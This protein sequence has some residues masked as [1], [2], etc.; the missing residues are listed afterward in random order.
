MGR[1]LLWGVLI[2]SVAA[3]FAGVA[4]HD[5]VVSRRELA[6]LSHIDE[7]AGAEQLVLSELRSNVAQR[8]PTSVHCEIDDT[9]LL[10]VLEAAMS[11]GSAA[12]AVD[13]SVANPAEPTPQ[14]VDDQGSVAARDRGLDIVESAIRGGRLTEREADELRSLSERLNAEDRTTLITTL[15]TAMNTQ[16]VR[17]DGPLFF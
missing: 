5:S 11:L 12:R 16:K 3:F 14:P 4:V 17:V 13:P 2:S 7:L 8:A 15:I 9:R 10:H 1:S 6:L